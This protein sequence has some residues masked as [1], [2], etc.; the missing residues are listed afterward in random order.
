MLDNMSTHFFRQIAGGGAD[1][2]KGMFGIISIRLVSEW[3]RT[4]H[5]MGVK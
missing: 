3:L 4:M 2:G 5:L 1:D